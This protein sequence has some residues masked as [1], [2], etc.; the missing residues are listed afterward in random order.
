MEEG[1][2]VGRVLDQMLSLD[3]PFLLHMGQLGDLGQVPQGHR[4]L[5][6]KMYLVNPDFSTL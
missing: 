3:F 2:T 5:K 6:P 4:R 1:N